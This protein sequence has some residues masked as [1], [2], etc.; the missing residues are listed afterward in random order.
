MKENEN[1]DATSV[2]KL[3]RYIM[4][5]RDEENCF[6]WSDDLEGFI[7]K[8]LGLSDP[9]GFIESLLNQGVLEE[10]V[11]GKLRFTGDSNN[12]K[13]EEKNMKKNEQSEGTSKVSSEDGDAV[14]KPASKEAGTI[15]QAM[16]TDAREVISD[17]S[18]FKLPKL[19]EYLGDEDEKEGVLEGV[20]WVKGKFGLTAILDLEEY[21]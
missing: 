10:P 9:T 17:S 20:R 16:L 8:R 14:Q 2:R 18:D 5:K 13:E 21:Q 4:N 19:S 7:G 3:Q 6:L 11:L 1:I 12:I 15:E